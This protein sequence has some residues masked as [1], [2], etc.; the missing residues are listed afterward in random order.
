MMIRRPCLLGEHKKK[1]ECGDETLLSPVLPLYLEE[2]A[3]RNKPMQKG[4]ATTTDRVDRF[5]RFFGRD[6]SVSDVTVTNFKD[7]VLS[8]KWSE[9]TRK[10]YGGTVSIF[11]AW[12]AKQGFGQNPLDWYHNTNSALAWEKG[13]VF[14]RLPGISTPEQTKALLVFMPSK[15]RSALAIMF[16]TGI[17]PELEM[18]MLRYSDIR[19]GRNYPPSN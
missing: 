5:L 14:S 7:Y 3:H 17:R 8:G 1:E 6:R 11:M 4:L 19:H 9:T 10:Q 16:F 13:K 2:Y 15:F 18:Q 12:C